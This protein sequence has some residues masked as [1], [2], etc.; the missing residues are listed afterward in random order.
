MELETEPVLGAEGWGGG[1]VGTDT[2]PPAI[3]ELGGRGRGIWGGCLHS[4][5]VALKLSELEKAGLLGPTP[6]LWRERE[7]GTRVPSAQVPRG[8]AA[9]STG[10]PRHT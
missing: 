6:E 3:E 7:G 2:F 1:T 8:R 10:P 5:T 9:A 4:S